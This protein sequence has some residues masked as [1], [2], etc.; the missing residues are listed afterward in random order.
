MPSQ[1]EPA[2]RLHR[3]RSAVL[4]VA[5]IIALALVVIPA[6][7]LARTHQQPPPSTRTPILLD[8]D[9]GTDI[10][11]AF[12]LA[13][14]LRSPELNLL[15]VTTVSGNTEARARLAAKMLCEAEHCDIPVAAGKPGKSL[16]IEQTH[17]ADNF[18]SSQLL[19]IHAA[20]FLAQQFDHKPGEITLI[21][22]GPLTNVA[23]LLQSDP[24]AAKEIHQI[25]MMG[26]SIARGYDHHKA[27]EPEYN[28]DQ[29]V[30]AARV[31]FSSGV[32][33]TMAP[34]DVTAMLDLDA[35]NRKRIF[36]AGTPL[37]KALAALYSLWGHPVPILFDPMAVAMLLKPGICTTKA[38]DITVDAK[39]FTRVVK[40]GKPNAV[41]GLH[42]DPAKFFHFY[43]SRV[44]PPAN[45]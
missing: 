8:T 45:R 39:G 19:S 15:G 12:A 18:S 44:A 9:I 27:P 22:I 30:A 40:E 6:R 20:D 13:L 29:D 14:I 7:L 11:D 33:I 4:A 38:L 23:A 10:D 28:I 1:P 42:T 36:D 2:H 26:G 35:K 24:K 32:P 5:I 3:R 16:P 41:V 21:A 17:W 25:V 43:M 34:L 37:S 31:V